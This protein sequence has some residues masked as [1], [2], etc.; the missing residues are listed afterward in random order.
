MKTST[1]EKITELTDKIKG[2]V[3]LGVTITGIYLA[4][5]GGLLV[6]ETGLRAGLEALAN[7]EKQTIEAHLEKKDYGWMMQTKGVL[8]YGIFK[9]SDGRTIKLC[10]S[11][12]VLDNKV[13]ENTV[14][15][16]MEEGK[17]YSIA[18]RSSKLLGDYCIN[19]KEIGK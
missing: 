11:Q 16:Q 3:L 6:V 4:A 8:Y 9:T 1:K 13:F 7:P 5:A 14:I 19:A 18:I 17:D 15:P 2:G 10:D 12:S